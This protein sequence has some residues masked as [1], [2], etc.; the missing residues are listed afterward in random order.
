M[1]TDQ[2]PDQA[3]PTS[4]EVIVLLL[5]TVADLCEI[6]LRRM[7]AEMIDDLTA[8]GLPCQDPPAQEPPAHHPEAPRG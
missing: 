8:S 3:P 5:S 6:E 7:H 2:P 4:L 1:A